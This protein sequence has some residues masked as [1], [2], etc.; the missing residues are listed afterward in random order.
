MRV[1]I[2]TKL[3]RCQS[4]RNVWQ[5]DCASVPLSFMPGCRSLPTPPELSED[6]K[7]PVSGDSIPSST[8][9]ITEEL[10]A[11]DVRHLQS[12]HLVLFQEG[13]IDHNLSSLFLLTTPDLRRP[14][15]KFF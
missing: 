6:I 11:E 8:F 5:R 9:L 10:P 3:S 15:K 14:R 7:K 2:N 12:V 13:T 4:P 1:C